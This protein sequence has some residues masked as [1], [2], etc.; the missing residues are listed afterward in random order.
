MPMP[1]GVQCTA[2]WMQLPQQ[3][4]MLLVPVAPLLL[5]TLQR[6]LLPPWRRKPL[7]QRMLLPLWRRKRL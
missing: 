4:L 2:L 1:R 7:P 6:R 5:G 3:K